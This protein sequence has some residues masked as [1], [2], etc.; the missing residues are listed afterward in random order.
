M[1]NWLAS[2]LTL[3]AWMFLTA[4]VPCTILYIALHR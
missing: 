3:L 1:P 2:L 4:A